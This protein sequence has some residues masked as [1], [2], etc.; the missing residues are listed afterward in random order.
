MHFGFFR[1]GLNP[2]ARERMLE[3]MNREVFTR[4]NVAHLPAPVIADLGCGLAATLRSISRQCPA[5]ELHGITVVPWQLH[6]GTELNGSG[7]EATPETRRIDLQVGDY[8]HTSFPA[9]S[10][11]AL[12]ALESSCYARDANKSAF[13]TEAFRLLRPGARLVIADGFLS[14]PDGLIGPQRTIC[15][16]LCT[17]WVIESLGEIPAVRAELERLGFEH[18]LIE[19]IQSRVTL[20]VLQV[21]FVTLKFL[22]TDVVFGSRKM[23]PAR[24]NNIIAPVLLPLVGKPVGPMAYYIVSAS[25]PGGDFPEP[26]QPA[27]PA[28]A[29]ASAL[30]T[31]AAGVAVGLLFTLA[32]VLLRQATTS[33][34][35]RP[36]AGNDEAGA[37]RAPSHGGKPSPEHLMLHQTSRNPESGG[38][39][40]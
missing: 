7:P 14:R 17:C 4:L 34:R 26:V 6:K 19:P 18:I 1:L 21:P 38:T 39:I 32:A 11:D 15:R 28:P 10:F 8:E 27:A 30:A 5:A 12:Y 37:G 16:V 23:S 2:F 24:W 36:Q 29:L 31:L 20:S 9:E 40:V 33:G 13:L 22:L 25:K 35:Q 3:Q